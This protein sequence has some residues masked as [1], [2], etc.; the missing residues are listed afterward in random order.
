LTPFFKTKDN[1]KMITKAG[2]MTI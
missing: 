2:G 1:L